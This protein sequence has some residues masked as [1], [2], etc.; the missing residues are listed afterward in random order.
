[1]PHRQ[2]FQGLAGIV[3]SGHVGRRLGLDCFQKRPELAGLQWHTEPQG[4]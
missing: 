1:M 3:C 2:K 4:R